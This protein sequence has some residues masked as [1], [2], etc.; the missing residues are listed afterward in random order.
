MWTGK[1]NCRIH[2]WNSLEKDMHVSKWNHILNW[3]KVLALMITATDN[4]NQ[5]IYL[6]CKIPTKPSTISSWLPGK[7]CGVVHGALAIM[8][9]EW[10]FEK[11][12]D[13]KDQSGSHFLVLCYCL[14]ACFSV[15]IL[16]FS[17]LSVLLG[18]KPRLPF[19]LSRCP[20]THRK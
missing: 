20:S 5:Q 16:A 18:E 14:Q 17:F 10:H 9:N 2:S 3:E 13:I 6:P 1:R 8:C 4:G 19:L 12:R 11:T 15:Q 7:E